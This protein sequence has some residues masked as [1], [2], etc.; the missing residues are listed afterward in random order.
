MTWQ[1]EAAC[2]DVPIHEIY[3]H[4][5]AEDREDVMQ[6]FAFL[7]CKRCPVKVPCLAEAIRHKDQYGVWGGILPG[8]DERA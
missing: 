7:Y 4:E 5:L 1:D 8:K 3:P 2:H 6:W